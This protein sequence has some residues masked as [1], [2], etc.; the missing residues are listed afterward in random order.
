VALYTR[1]KCKQPQTSNSG[2]RKSNTL[3]YKRRKKKMTK[4]NFLAISIAILLAISMAAS[5]MLV[6]E[7]N[8]HTPSWDIPTFA[9]IYVATN[10]IGVGQTAYIYLF[11]TPTYADTNVVNDYRFHN[12]QLQITAPDGK[13]TTQTYE[14]IMDT[15][16]NQFASFTPDQVGTYN[17]TFN[18]P[19]QNVNDYSHSPTSQYANDTYLPSSAK[20]TLTVQEDQ[21]SYLP[22]SP[23]PTEFWTRP[24]FGENSMWWS[25]S[26][27]W[28]GSGMPGYGG[29]NGPNQ[30][31]FA[32][33][34]IGSQ[35][36]HIMWTVPD[37]QIGGVVGGN[38][39]NVQGDTWFEGTA[40]SQRY[41]NPIILNGKIYYREPLSDA[42]TAGP[43]VCRDLV[44]G[45]LIWS[46]TDLPTFSFGYI[47]DMDTPDYHGVRPAYLC[48][49]NFGQVYDATTGNTAFNVSS[50]PSGTNVIGPMGELIKY[51]FFNN[52]TNSNPDWYLYQWNSS[53]FWSQAV[54]G[55]RTLMTTTTT[56]TT[57]VTS[58]QYVNGV[59]ET[60]LTPVTTRTTFINAGQNTMYDWLNP[61][62]QNQSISWR[63]DMSPSPSIIG[64]IYGDIL[65]CRSG[66]YPS[67]G[68]TSAGYTYFAV[69]LNSSKGVV[70]SILWS[71][72]IP[73][74]A[75]NI[76]T[77][78]FAGLD[79]SGYFCESYRQTQQFVFYNLR[80]GAHIKTSDPQPA[81]DYYGSNGPGTL[82]NCIAYGRCYSSAYS[83]VLY[84]YDMA[85]GNVL[86]T[87]GNGGVPGN[88][89]YSGFQAPGP[90]PTFINAI[91][92]GIVYTV[93]SEHTFETPIY[94]GAL[95]RAINATDGTEIWTLPAATGEFTGESYA[96]ADG[97]SNFFNSYDHQIYTLGK[98]PSSLTV[99]AGPKCTT[100]GTNV[101]IEGT[102]TDLSA[103]TK[104]T[105]QAARFPQGVP[106]SSDQSMS[107]WMQYVYQQQPLPSN[108]QGVEVGLS[109]VDANGNYR[110]IGTAT[111]DSKGNFNL[112]WTPD[113]P[114][115]FNVIAAFGGTNGYWPS[116]QE[117]VF[118][119]IEPQTTTPQPTTN[120]V[121]L[122]DQYILPMG[123]AI[124]VAIFIVGAVIAVL[125]RKRP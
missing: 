80:T 20:A 61:T 31:Q 84:C 108:F 53:R 4:K 34:A 49:S 19:G 81:L 36:P 13:Q 65:L 79:P 42:G 27:N 118:N 120:A 92:N 119:V 1:F 37:G 87:Y 28:L 60:V 57:N 38:L 74:P 78:S 22:L 40:Y 100:L 46:R 50:V 10:P 99:Q 66:S 115:T 70:G 109:V 104:Q 91:A 112:V 59:L 111:T 122:A 72:N 9:H 110:D 16:S 89:T 45:Q 48:T 3:A 90:Y 88:D 114:G 103:G 54:M 25:I 75:G 33:D 86:W 32:P 2:R 85:T 123:I 21:I 43:T 18:F 14:T 29:S 95:N 6:P 69:N 8:A 76:T 125:I 67:L 58:T 55:A 15:T 47:Q 68:G 44:T 51:N 101:I 52:G 106:V 113:I 73:N 102:V 97:Y 17:L 94:K 23:L 93:T 26:S 39:A 124:I 24:I 62:T 83:G 82:S 96:V 30:R 56:T 5:I 71:N 35:T 117:T 121:S 12:Y 105:E 107:E 77:I 98:G 63:N 116:Y 41:V 7:T 64:A 11:L